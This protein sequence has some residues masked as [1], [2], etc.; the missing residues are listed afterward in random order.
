MSNVKRNRAIRVHELLNAKCSVEELHSGV[1]YTNTNDETEYIIG[2]VVYRTSYKGMDIEFRKRKQEFSREIFIFIDGDLKYHIPQPVKSIGVD[3]DLISIVCDENHILINTKT[4][5][6][7]LTEL[8]ASQR[9][10]S[11]IK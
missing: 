6:I 5:K 10:I 8:E 4:D 11:I 2:D 7:K 3:G 1:N 9:E